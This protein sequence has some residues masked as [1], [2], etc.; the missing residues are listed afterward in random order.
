MLPGLCSIT[1]LNGQ[2]AFLRSCHTFLKNKINHSN[3]RREEEE[4]EERERERER[5]RE[6][7]M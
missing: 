1:G 4:E 3:R 2:E 5:E 6:D 7:D